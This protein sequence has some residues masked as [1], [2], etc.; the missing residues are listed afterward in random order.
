MTHL[1]V[2]AT[3]TSVSPVLIADLQ[4]WGKLD[5]TD[6][7]QGRQHSADGTAANNYREGAIVQDSVAPVRYLITFKHSNVA[8][9]QYWEF[10]TAAARNTAFTADVT[11]PLTTP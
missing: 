6:P 8:N 7:A 11:T 4:S 9:T 10:A 5:L 3:A 2:S 1:P